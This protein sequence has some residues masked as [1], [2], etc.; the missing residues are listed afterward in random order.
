MAIENSTTRESDNPD[1]DSELYDVSDMDEDIYAPENRSQNVEVEKS[2]IEKYFV[3]E[4]IVHFKV[5]TYY[6]NII[7]FIIII[8]I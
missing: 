8:N 2:E 3:D 6:Y 5:C 1:P 4:P 7:V